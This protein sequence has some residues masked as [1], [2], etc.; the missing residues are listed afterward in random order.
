MNE[1]CRWF[2][3]M[4]YQSSA[5]LSY[6]LNTTG[7]SRVLNWIGEI[8]QLLATQR[9]ALMQFSVWE[10]K[11][12]NSVRRMPAW[13]TAIIP[14]LFTRMF[15]PLKMWFSKATVF[16]IFNFF[17]SLIKFIYKHH[18]WDRFDALYDYA[19]SLIIR[20]TYFINVDKESI[21]IQ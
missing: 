14:L 12:G 13:R 4:G 20:R 15:L 6:L 1:P 17:F 21:P 2:N 3:R 7:S 5:T 10:K 11:N 19:L 9:N 8:I 16:H 18:I